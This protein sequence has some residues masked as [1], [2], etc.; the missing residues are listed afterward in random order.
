[1]KRSLFRRASPHALAALF[2][3]V[4]CVAPA[5][6]R[7]QATN[8]DTAQPY[9]LASDLGTTVN[10]VFQG[11]VLRTDQVNGAYADN[12]TLD[13]S[14]SNTIDLAGAASTFSGVF[15]DAAGGAPGSLIINDSVG[16][17]AVTLSGASTYTGSTTISAGTL[18]LSLTGNIASSSGLSLTGASAVFDASNVGVGTQI[19]SL[20]GVAG[21]KVRLGA[22]GL[23]VDQAGATTFAG[24]ITG[25]GSSAFIKTGS[26]ALTLSGD[27]TYANATTISGGSL[28][29]A[30]SGS[31]AASSGVADDA[32]FDIS[33]TTA[34]A[35]ITSLSGGG[36]VALG[37]QTLTLTN[38]GDTFSGVIDGASGLAVAGGAETLTGV[39]TYAGATTINS[40]ASLLLSGTGG[41]ASSSGV[42][43]DGTFDISATTSGA[44]IASLS[45]AGVVNLG[46]Q[47]LTLT[48]ASGTFSGGI[49]GTGGLVLTAGTETLTGANGYTGGTT[50]LGG[51]MALSGPGSLGATTGTLTVAS[52][53][54]DLG[55]TTQTTG[56]LT[57]NGGAI[58]DSS[59]GGALDS[60]AFDVRSGAIDAVLGGSGALT[61]TGIGVT[62]LSRVN[63]Y[64]GSTTISAGVLVL[65]GAGS[66]AASSGVVD[67]AFLDIS[68][69]AAGASI[70]TLSGGG[71]VALGGQTLTLTN[72]GGVFS[73]AVVGGAG[74]LT[75]AG[76][77]E[78]LT[79]VNDYAGATTINSGANLQL[80]GTGGVANSSGV[81]DNGTF[82]IAATTSGASITSLSGAGVVNLG[83][84]TLT[85]TNA[86]GTF[87]GD[88]AG[89]GDLVLAAGTETLS[90]ANG[91]SGGTT[92][93]GGVLALS[94]SGSLGA[95]TGT[96][97]IF[98]G[99]LDLGGT[100]Q[101]TGAF[102]LNS[103]ALIDSG[104]G[105]LDA[106]A[107]DLR[108]GAIDAVL[109][110]SGAL[111]QNGLG[112]TLYRANTYTGSTTISVGVLALSGAGSIATS[113]GVADDALLDI[114]ATTAGASVTSLSGGGAVALGGQTLTLTNAGGAFGGVIDGAGGL[115]AAGG[116]ETLSGV[117]TYAGATTINSGASLLLSGT[118]AIASSSGVADD[119]TFDISATTSGAS[120]ATLSGAGIVNLGAQTLTLTNASGTFSGG[121]TGTGG[122]AITAGSTS[123]T[124]IS[125]YAGP[126]SVSNAS[127]AINSDASLGGP[128]GALA[129]NN[130]SLVILGDM[131][132]ARAITLAVADTIDT[133]G[134]R[135]QLSGAI[136]GSGALTVHGGGQLTLAGVN[137]YAGATSI[138]HG[139]SLWL[140]GTGGIANSSGVADDGTFDISTTASGASIATLSGAGIVN[141]GAQTLTLTNASG[142]FSGSI[143]G[144]GGVAITGGSEALTGASTYAGPTSVSNA[145]LY[146]N[147][148][149]SLGGPGGALALNNAALVILGD[150]S[151]ARAVTLTG[152]DTVDTAGARLQLSGAIGGNGGLIVRG[153]G[154]LSLTGINTYAGGSLVTGDATLAVG[155]DAALGAPGGGLTLDRGVLMAA[156]DLTTVRSILIAAGGGVIDSNG[157]A[158]GL[159]G[160]ITL[161]GDLST[162][163]A[164]AITLSSVAQGTGALSI[165]AGL[166]ADNGVI[167]AR[168]VTVAAGA[169]LRGV[170]VINA[171]TTISGTL[172]PGNSPGT[173]TFNAALTLQAGA[174]SAFDIDG[175]GTGAGAGNFSRVIV[176]GANGM[177]VGGILSPRLRGMTGSASNTYSPSIGQ[178]F[179][180]IS[181][182]GGIAPTSS[183]SGLIQPAGLAAGTRF[184]ALYAPTTV[185]LVVTPAAYANLAAAGI[186]ETANTRAIGAVLDAGRP[187]AGVRMSATQAAVYGPLYNL[188]AAQIPAVLEGLSPVIYA[189]GLM[190]A[191]QGWYGG[192]VAVSDQLANRRG[193]PGSAGPDGVTVWAD[194]IGQVGDTGPSGG[195][196]R[197]SFGGVIVG[198]D[199]ALDGG[200]LIGFA[201]GAEDL[202][203][204]AD[205]GSAS[206]VQFQATA[207]G[208]ARRGRVFVDGQAALMLMDQHLTRSPGL[209]GAPIESRNTLKGVGAQVNAGLDLTVDQW[210]VE[211]TVGLSTLGLAS[212]ATR[213]TPNATMA[214]DIRAQN[215]ASVQSFAGV[216]LA[217]TMRLMGDTPLRVSGI[218]GWTHEMA[219]TN[220]E[221]RASF[222]N[223]GGAAF[224]V[225]SADTSRDAARLGAS[226]DAQLTS[227]VSVYGS[228]SVTLTGGGSS[229]HLA[230]S[231]RVRW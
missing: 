1:M 168:S 185:T 100:T 157:Q 48:N 99:T 109:G 44:S 47:T 21:S 56:A 82:D 203:T 59:G 38:A 18:S 141:L 84:Q 94:G 57:L 201:L 74:G 142:T 58:I 164:G 75:V 46:S 181:A 230:A 183:F 209:G 137:T 50:I 13:G 172:A 9:Y 169:T 212:T 36:A 145:S 228:Y 60:S 198:I 93:S 139:A 19:R 39:N 23:T 153:G 89:T 197:T 188:S 189:D 132:S 178:R 204:A 45:G 123:L 16:G 199:K 226:V 76:G 186:V 148:D 20:S 10:P 217:R 138:N 207:Y 49:S 121:I 158:V 11:G 40:G 28:A 231:V 124:G 22:K 130:A 101:T 210:L 51:V 24:Q 43:D 62:T 95:A 54:L 86:S 97:T 211:P 106:S 154:Q 206:G 68:T 30:G 205:A 52:G 83:G 214:E 87:S 131:T 135:L 35:S 163:G 2:A 229:Q 160:P 126:T 166:F 29:L 129:L 27:N 64:T 69:T 70:T 110:G 128:S 162:R 98:G 190:A 34:G 161:N 173:L 215:G 146:V 227:R 187:A 193:A 72:A 112:V 113:S 73:G 92:V 108:R 194:G 179:Q 66:I 14:G 4:E 80:S 122:L 63:T 6:A 133:A 143:S 120:V 221:A 191:R 195:A 155:S 177:T 220:A 218:A 174:T 96:L 219:D 15:S 42:A 118:G 159:D 32:I 103:G 176:N 202:Q 182:A 77:A 184:D 213:E 171:P 5:A 78:T 7:A 140:S 104:G 125:T 216:R 223:L 3:I 33:A 136:G 222:S 61:Q 85:L 152:A 192:A 91:Y 180:I 81:A 17:G 127:L 71:Q 165:T 116:A 200:G 41:V 170:G 117:N 90:G 8:I 53:T 26:G 37:G 67:N 150:M 65:S 149:A 119:G 156:G 79:G 225:T 12:F 55:G 134:A 88:I 31:I 115:T 102:V 105:A 147:S 111:T 151:S 196:Y 175:P 25:A 107:F 224:T 208:A 167:S 144:T 114:S